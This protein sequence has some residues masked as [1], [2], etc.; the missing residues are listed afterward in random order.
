LS[1]AAG[2]GTGTG[3]DLSRDLL[4][5]IGFLVEVSA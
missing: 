4:G 3:S 1:A 5:L 2:T